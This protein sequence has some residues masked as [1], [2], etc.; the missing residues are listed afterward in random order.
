MSV[1][2]WWSPLSFHKH[3]GCFPIRQWLGVQKDGRETAQE[4]RRKVQAANDEN[5]CS[6]FVTHSTKSRCNCLVE[7]AAI[8]HLVCCRLAPRDLERRKFELHASERNTQRVGLAF[9]SSF[10][11]H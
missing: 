11:R 10:S 9:S 2:W 7:L 4:H 8:G 6:V 5:G 3:S 1:P